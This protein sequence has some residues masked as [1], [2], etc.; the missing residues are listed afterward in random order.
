MGYIK[1]FLEWVKNLFYTPK[2]EQTLEWTE[3][4]SSLQDYIEEYMNTNL[5]RST[6]LHRMARE[7][8]LELVKSFSHGSGFKRVTRQWIPPNKGI[9]ENIGRFYSTPAKAMHAWLNSPGHLALL[10]KNWKYIGI[11]VYTVSEKKN[12][13]CLLLGN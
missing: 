8:S 12:Y 6:H 3:Y 1:Q 5:T 11:G 13:I 7:R 10:N 9:G 2:F 4:E